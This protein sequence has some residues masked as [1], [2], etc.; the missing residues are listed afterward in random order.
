MDYQQSTEKLKLKF[1]DELNKLSSRKYGEIFTNERYDEYISIL[2]E[3]PSLSKKSK[4]QNK[5]FHNK[6]KKKF[7][8]KEILINNEIKSVLYRRDCGLKVNKQLFI[9]NK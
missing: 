9:N 8:I 4:R 3:Y 2:R 1:T 5:D 7:E 6:T